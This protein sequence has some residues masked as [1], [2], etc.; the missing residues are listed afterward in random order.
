MMEALR[1]AGKSWVAKLL[2]LLLAGSFGIWGMQD[3]FRGYR[4]NS[5]ARVGNQEITPQEF[6]T[7]FQRALQ[8]LAR[9][10]GQTLTQEEAK[11]AG[12][13]KT[14]LGNL[15]QSAALDEKAN[16]L[17]IMI[18][19]QAIVEAAH[20]MPAFK[21]ADG[22]FDPKVFAS[23][24]SQNGLSET[25]FLQIE[26]RNRSREALTSTVNGGFKPPATLVE[27]MAKYREEQRDAKYF[28]ITASDSDVALPSDEEMKKQY[29]ATPA[30]YTA[31]EFRSIAI[32]KVEP[33]D[34]SA[35][36][37]ISDTELKAG[38]DKYK[39]DYF[40]PEKRT[41][42][43]IPF[44]T[45]QQ[46][47]EAKAKIA[48]GTDFLQIARDRKI[49]DTDLTLADKTKSDFL[50]KAVGDAAFALKQGEVSDVV[51]GGLV[52]ALLKAQTVTPE[53]QATLDEVK[54]PLT[55]RLQTEKAQ[56]QIQTIFDGVENAR[57]NKTPFEDIA[58]SQGIPFIL[59]P[60][61]SASGLGKDGKDVEMPSKQEVLKA[62]FSS[63]VG[64][65]NEALHPD[66]SYFWYDVREVIPSALK[67]FD[68]VKE[69]V[70][71]DVISRK[72]RET[73][74]ERAGKIVSAL[75]AGS[76]ME[77][78]ATEAKVAV[79]QVTGLK[80]NEATAEFDIPSLT[81]LFG[82]PDNGFAW[83]LEGDGRSAKI[84]QSTPV[85]AAPFDSKSPLAQQVAQG[86][87]T[88]GGNDMVSAYLASLKGDVG[89][90][91]NDGLWQ[92][93]SGRSTA[94]P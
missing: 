20:A 92:Q 65:E 1:N 32:L 30:A 82:V 56:E 43:Q 46:A 6:N 24:L 94:T 87:E 51:K 54:G 58:K 33:K 48:A 79:K 26:S 93:V 21:G 5:L 15:V 57:N 28:L 36:I 34:I 25:A 40:T 29:A 45:E 77:K 80:R 85:M 2:L 62:A 47:R 38:Y 55:Q 8:N 88:A 9:Q 70:K 53:K 83:S 17:K 89:V 63:D 11:K 68:T 52:T 49:G 73:L 61:V 60:A 4:A 59:V 67:T 42:L 76:A 3:V 75:K 23:V 74:G 18:A 35:K 86:L 37:A 7:A 90:S 16:R 72:I 71:S 12:Y 41:I 84:M 19:P 27:A 81:A 13:D 14:V 78:Q 31:P 22:K 66:D 44:D 69:Q 91:I 10:S 64:V 39:A 50:D